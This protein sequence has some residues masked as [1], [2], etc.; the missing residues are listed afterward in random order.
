MIDSYYPHRGWLPLQRETLEALRRRKVER[1]LPTYDEAVREL[2][3]A[4][5]DRLAPEAA[6]DERSGRRGAGRLA[7]V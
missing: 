2:L 5:E 7:A 1:G 3:E 4:A 6:P